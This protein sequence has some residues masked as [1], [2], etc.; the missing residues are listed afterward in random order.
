[1]NIDQIARH[2][3]ADFD[4]GI[5][6]RPEESG[7]RKSSVIS[8][9]P[10]PAV[11]SSSTHSSF[12]IDTVNLKD[13]LG[14]VETDRR[15]RH[16]GGSFASVTFDSPSIARRCSEGA[17]HPIRSRRS[18]GLPMK[19]GRCGTMTHDYRRHGTTTLFAAL[20][21]LVDKAG[22]H[23][24]D[25]LVVPANITPVFLPPY[26]PELNPIERLWLYLGENGLSHRLFD[27]T[28]EIIDACRDAW[29]G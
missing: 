12:G 6:L 25:E 7:E 17:I 26:S 13:V 4:V 29:N 15:H 19:K 11:S 1:L 8:P 20:D 10:R 18:P 28:A 3:G 22:W 9:S 23:I 21:V 2:W 5:E 14:Q 27:T 16:Q 24:A